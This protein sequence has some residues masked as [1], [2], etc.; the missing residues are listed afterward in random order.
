MLNGQ[1]VEVGETVVFNMGTNWT[2]EH[3]KEYVITKVG[4]MDENGWFD[5]MVEGDRDWHDGL[6]F[7]KKIEAPEIPGFE[8]TRAALDNL[9]I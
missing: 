6:H 3:N 5:I 9:R 1:K 2:F 4:D 8:G 7:S